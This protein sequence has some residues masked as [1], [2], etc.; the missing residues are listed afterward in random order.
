MSYLNPPYHNNFQELCA[1]MPI[2]YLDV[3]EMR[4]ILRAQGRLLDGA[5]AGL[6]EIVDANFILTANEAT[7]RQWERV[8]KITY[9][10]RLTLEQR[11]RVVIGYIIGFGHIGEPEIRAIIAQY[12]PNHVDFDFMRGLITIFI[13]GEV[14]D[15]D[16]MLNTLL[17]RIPAHLGLN[18]T[19][20]VRREYR[21]DLTLL[22]GGAATIHIHGDP[23][24]TRE[25]ITSM[26]L[27]S[28]SA[29]SGPA[30]T[31][32]TPTVAWTART[33][34]SLQQSGAIMADNDGGDTPPVHWAA[35]DTAH[36][37]QS[38]VSTA[39][40]DGGDTPPVR[41]IFT[42]AAPMTQS[43]ASTSGSDGGDTPPVRRTFTGDATVAHS[44]FGGAQ[45]TTDIPAT[46][47]A[48]T[49]LEKAAGGLLCYTHIKSKRID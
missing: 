29:A 5:C 8:F 49:G 21:Q 32:D 35:L 26:L 13:D 22:Q 12:T 24:E 16:N 18:I 36:L 33:Q 43:G 48:S 46:K 34:Y 38:G 19:V 41:R 37:T 2:F 44:G 17:R 23:A 40:N 4:A 25:T 1:A 6:E 28:Q 45:A 20:H 30:F 47:R 14:F 3:F 39:E 10:S 15:E 42:G 31:S 27:L 7:I 9:K 11:R